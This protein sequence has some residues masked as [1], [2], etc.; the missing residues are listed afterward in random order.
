MT[1]ARFLRECREGSELP[2]QDERKKRHTALRKACVAETLG[3]FFI[4]LLGT[5]VVA[6][7]EFAQAEV[8][9]LFGIAVVWG[10]AVAGAA[11]SFGKVSGSHFNPAI[12]LALW[13]KLRDGAT[14]L[15]VSP[16]KWLRQYIL[17]QLLGATLGSLLVGFLFQGSF[18]RLADPL[19]GDTPSAPPA[20]GCYPSEEYGLSRAIAAEIVGTAMLGFGALSFPSAWHLGPWL[21][22]LIIV[23]APFSGASFNPARELGP[24]LVSAML[25]F[26]ASTVV[27]TALGAYMLAPVAGAVLGVFLACYIKDAHIH[28]PRPHHHHHRRHPAHGT[29]HMPDTDVRHVVLHHPSNLDPTSHNPEPRGRGRHG[30]SCDQ[31]SDWSRD[32]S[33]GQTCDQ[34]HADT[35]CGVEIPR[36]AGVHGLGVD[37]YQYHP[38]VPRHSVDA[39]AQHHNYHPL[40]PL[41]PQPR[42]E[43]AL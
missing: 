9:G 38:L 18:V 32:Q 16:S 29:V 11:H 37:A 35:A 15:H 2:G 42:A 8:G 10:V 26:D 31:S 14:P 30:E 17:S 43:G 39:D 41:V 24:R 7:A 27:G 23:F 1:L 19:D 4:V 33:R 21:A 22:V 36:V 6:A 28:Q 12:S 20:M 40:V 5:G 34:H 25:G 3:T 13:L